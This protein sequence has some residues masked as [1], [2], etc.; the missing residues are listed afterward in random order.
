VEATIAKESTNAIMEGTAANVWVNHTSTSTLNE[1]MVLTAFGPEGWQISCNKILIP[2]QGLQF[3]S[4]PGH[5][6]PQGTQSTC[7]IL[8]LS[9]TLK[10]DVSFT[11]SSIDGHHTFTESIALEY[12]S[13]DEEQLFSNTQLIAGGSGGLIFIVALLFI[14]RRR[15]EEFGLSEEFEGEKEVVPIK[16]P[17]INGPPASE[18]QQTAQSDHSAELNHQSSDES[19]V[20]HSPPPVPDSGLPQGW[21]EEQWSYYGQQY[22]DGTL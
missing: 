1:T 9:G 18:I 11:L 16:G 4:P 19:T 8:R 14:L 6:T 13:T 2:E 5:V 20:Q 15:G 7:E 3:L 22:L 10:G 12:E 21:S 17:P